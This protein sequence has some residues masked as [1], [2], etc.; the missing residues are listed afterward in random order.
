MALT[1]A[2]V[3]SGPESLRRDVE[4]TIRTV[5]CQPRDR[6]KIAA[7]VRDMRRRI[8][9]EKGSSDPWDL[10]Y[11]DGGLIDIEFIAQYLQLIHAADHPDILDQNTAR[12]LEKLR[13]EGLIGAGDAEIVLSAAHLYQALSQIMR[14]CQEGRFDPEKAPAGLKA[15]LSRAVA[16][17]DF[18]RVAPTLR[19]VQE[20][21]AGCFD[22]L[23]EKG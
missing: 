8:A 12:A 20:A 11:V 17:P 22:R 1:R 10:K 5:L 21:V 7:D 14:L 6:V 23:I 4:E 19:E 3:V 2:R 13:D 9:Q 16:V 15:M 18:S